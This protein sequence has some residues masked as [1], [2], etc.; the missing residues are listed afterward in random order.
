MKGEALTLPGVLDVGRIPDDGWSTMDNQPALSRLELLTTAEL[1]LRLL[2]QGHCGD[3]V[4]ALTDILNKL[5]DLR[6]DFLPV[7]RLRWA[8]GTAYECADHADL[9][10]AIKQYEGALESGAP[11]L[12]PSEQA[13]IW[14]KRGRAYWRLTGAAR[15]DLIDEAVRSYDQALSYFSRERD[16]KVWAEL[17]QNR[18]QAYVEQ[19]SLSRE[20]FGSNLEARGRIQKALEEALG[21]YRPRS[22]EW[23]TC[24]FTLAMIEVHWPGPARQVH[25]EKGIAH[26][27]EALTA[28]PRN[29][30]MG[31]ADDL[32][33]ADLNYDFGGPRL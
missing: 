3:A 28:Y 29:V 25:I 19:L 5:G 18:A 16:E 2:L 12:D 22:Q 33:D 15:S 24:V 1:A 17:V 13:W 14:L 30:R 27:K 23:A 26:Y 20:R 9:Q 21:S 7:P 11:G 31:N 4:N 10:L 8:L 32:S 6:D